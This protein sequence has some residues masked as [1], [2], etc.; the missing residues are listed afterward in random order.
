M[1][2]LKKTQAVPVE[3]GFHRSLA[4]PQQAVHIIRYLRVAHLR[5]KHRGCTTERQD[6]R[7][8]H[9]IVGK[10]AVSMSKLESTNDYRVTDA[11][12]QP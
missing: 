1:I 2:D 4:L 12:P 6:D 7:A 3:S 11:K 10:R 8:V 9:G 5:R